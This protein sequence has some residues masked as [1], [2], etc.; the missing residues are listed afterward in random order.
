MKKIIIGQSVYVPTTEHGFALAKVTRIEPTSISVRLE[1]EFLRETY[2]ENDIIYMGANKEKIVSDYHEV[3]RPSFWM[4]NN[5]K[6]FPEWVTQQF[7][8]FRTCQKIKRPSSKTD[9]FTLYPYQEFVR[10]YLGHTSPYRGLLLYHGLGT[11][12][13]C[14]AV[15]IA[16]NLKDTRNI[17]ILLPASL[18][19]NFIDKGLKTCGSSAYRQDDKLI[20]EKYTFISYNA[21]NLVKQL[22]SL[23]SL[24]N[25]VIII[26]EGHNVATM[27]VNGLRGVG[28]Q[29]VEL[30][31]QLM[32]AK[33]SKIIVLT[34]TPL[35]NT[36]FEAAILLNIVRGPLE[37]TNFIIKRAT[38]LDNYVSQLSQDPRIG[39]VDVNRRNNTLMV[40]LRVNSWD[41]EFEQTI[42]FI[43]NK[44]KDFQVLLTYQGTDRYPLFPENEDEFESYF[45]RKGE[46]INKNM[47]QRRILGL[48]SFYQG[49]SQQNKD[50]PTLLPEKKVNVIMSTH[51]F[52]LYEQAREK[53]REKE[54]RAAYQKRTGKEEQQ[55]STLARVFSREFSNFVFPDDIVRP[56][57]AFEFITR[58]VQEEQEQEMKIRIKKGEIT[59]EQAQKELELIK[60]QRKQMSP[61]TLD[62]QIQEALQKISD[63]TKPYLKPIP[64][65][66]DR[67]S[68]KMASMLSFLEK[69]DGLI[70]VYSNF[71]RVEG[72]EIFARILE[73]NGYFR[74]N[75]TF[76]K[77]EN[78]KRFAFYSG[79]EDEKER[80]ATTQI[81]TS[82]ENKYGE[83]IKILLVSPAGAEGL[84]LKNIRLVMIMEP[85]WHE[86]RIKQVIGRAVRKNSHKDLP[87]EERT[88]QVVRFLSILST[89]QKLE[90]KEKL[91]SDEYV[92][93]IAY[94]KEK[95]NQDVMEAIKEASVDCELNQCDNQMT[96]RCFQ[97]T[98]PKEGLAYLPDIHKD[99]VYGY[100]ETQVQEVTKELKVGAVTEQ[101]EILFK[102]T[103]DGPWY[104]ADGT[105]YTQDVKLK[106]KDN[107]VLF[108]P[109]TL[110]VYDYLAMKENKI[111][112]LLGKIIKNVWKK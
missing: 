99:V 83:K 3:H 28:K 85:Y 97:F 63:P 68:P 56:F 64:S 72:L 62:T 15:A 46:F 80:K 66:L 26:E 73:A 2:G 92:A 86:V 93:E 94:Q 14:A 23:G 41:M 81:F 75:S 89:E 22:E 100:T 9:N 109:E 88:V 43:E 67:Y 38:N 79:V 6:E 101:N 30:Y 61:E 1:D 4:M 36:P 49:Q 27:A 87:P 58:A 19:T 102:K 33:N 52:E 32:E 44:A 65:G 105:E 54:R 98:S 18:K 25:K 24:D 7:H 34:G 55:V 45:V 5:R 37:L 84:D 35:V 82:S 112:I 77:Q 12:K 21:S 74:Y 107:K 17:V 95:L 20:Q 91:S 106:K 53:E 69:Q 11:G 39:F 57:K 8:L 110:Q 70:L 78:F 108:D 13:T 40:V 51:Q 71:R 31:R 76:S 111:Q 103:K 104:L 50:Y 16:E 59:A 96:G 48:V 47:F 10:D 29:G 90:G 42:R 60:E